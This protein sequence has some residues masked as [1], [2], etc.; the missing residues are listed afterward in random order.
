MVDDLA[1]Q[2]EID[3]PSPERKRTGVADEGRQPALPRQLRRCGV[4]FQANSPEPD[5]SSGRPFDGHLRQVAGA[6]PDIEEGERRLGD[7]TA[8]AEESPKATP[9][10]SAPAEPSIGP[11]DVAERFPYGGWWS[12]RIIEELDP[13]GRLEQYHGNPAVTYPPR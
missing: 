4:P 6:G 2:D 8:L 9:D 10:R 1:Q 11:R 12:G 7:G 3:A 5:S 13:G